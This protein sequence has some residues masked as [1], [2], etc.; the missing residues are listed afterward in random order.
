MKKTILTLTVMLAAAALVAVF[1]GSAMA[2][3]A[4]RCDNC[5]TM[6]ASQ[7]PWNTNWDAS[8]E[9]NPEKYLL[10]RTCVG[11]HSHMTDVTYTIGT[12]DAVSTVPVVYTVAAP[13]EYLAGGNF[14]WVA[15]AS[16][17]P[18]RK[19]HNVYGISLADGSLSEAPGN[20]NGTCEGNCHQ[21]LATESA[22]CTGCHLH[23]RHH[24]ND[25]PI[26]ESGLVD[27][28]DQGWYR[29]LSGHDAEVGVRGYEHF[30]WEKGQ[31][32]LAVGLSNNHNQYL[33]EELDHSGSIRGLGDATNGTTTAYCC[34]CHGNFHKQDPTTRS[35]VLRDWTRHPSDAVIPNDAEYAYYTSYDPLSPVAMPIDNLGT[36]TANVAPGTDM[37]MCLS[38][39]R[40]HG[41]PYDD[42]L[43]WD[44]A[45]SSAGSGDTNKGCF[46]CHTLKD[47]E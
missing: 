10:G 43:R 7:T 16:E 27:S 25:H 38:C 15:H 46:A 28:Y 30:E 40:P 37:V 33:G 12:G 39:H 6:H 45:A 34:G 3:V 1:C 21:S 22:G 14:H 47:N 4:G 26:G 13:T 24:A 18:D 44:Y 17:Y 9:G 36:L 23:P 32:T 29:F 5:H 41:S 35:G 42:L 20:P 2:K 19:G 31:P 8:V 11:C